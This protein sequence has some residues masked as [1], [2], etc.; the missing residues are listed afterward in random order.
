MFVRHLHH[1]CVDKGSWRSACAGTVKASMSHCTPPQLLNSSD[2]TV[3]GQDLDDSFLR[4]HSAPGEMMEPE[5]RLPWNNNGLPNPLT[6]RMSESW[7]PSPSS[8]GIS[9]A[10]TVLPSCCVGESVPSC[11]RSQGI[12]PPQGTIKEKGLRGSRLERK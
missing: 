3:I 8:C 12:N 11:E 9:D 10:N 6:D 5:T 2:V 4:R 1:V 7:S